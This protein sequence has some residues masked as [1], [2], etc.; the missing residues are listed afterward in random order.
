[1][2]VD[3]AF[4]AELRRLVEPVVEGHGLLFNDA[5]GD[6]TVLF[7][8]PADEADLWIRVT[9][10]GSIEAEVGVELYRAASVANLAAALAERYR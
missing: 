2:P 9:D 1:V 7:E 3:P 6:G 4:V 10:D 8:A 5:M